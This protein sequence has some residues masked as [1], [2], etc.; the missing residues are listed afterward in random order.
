MSM[1]C[2]STCISGFAAAVALLAFI[3]DIA[4]FFA[5]RARINSVGSA[6]LGNATWLTLAAWVLL[7]FSGCF[8]TIG[9]C[10]ISKRG[11]RW[12]KDNR[13]KGESE[14]EPGLSEA[15]RL[16]AVKAE[17]DR[18]VRQ[19]KLEGGLPAFHEVQPLTGH[20]D[21]DKVHVDDPSRPIISS[22]YGGRTAY[23]GTNGGY[24]Q[25]PPGTRAV[26]EYYSPTRTEYAAPTYPPALQNNYGPTGYAPSTAHRQPSSH[27]LSQYSHSNYEPSTY[28]PPSSEQYVVTN[29]PQY[30][31]PYYN[32][33]APY[34]HTE[35]GSSH[36]QVVSSHARP[37]TNYTSYDSYEP[38]QP[39]A[40][41]SNHNNY[42]AAPAPVVSTSYALDTSNHYQT[43]TGPSYQNEWSSG[44]TAYYNNGYGASFVP[45][46]SEHG[47]SYFPDQTTTSPPPVNVNAAYTPSQNAVIPP[48]GRNKLQVRNEDEAP[49]TYE[50]GTSTVQ[51][52]WGKQS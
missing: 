14:M 21:G 51:G 37:R 4:I 11:P 1:T 19:N 52:S 27:A 49:P 10:C 5:A 20:I 8:Y 3:F 28:T 7:F 50:A 6:E 13:S 48:Q 32:T 39:T 15:I 47:T 38:Q 22:S 17:A 36:H 40:Y 45:P 24:V 34:G 29:Q 35:G 46:L 23:E 9:R 12:N 2:F 41:S 25:K 33:S 31:D 26:D 43:Q 44:N 30:P 18:K 16:D 42:S